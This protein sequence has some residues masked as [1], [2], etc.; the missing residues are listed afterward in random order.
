MARR[1]PVGWG[2]LAPRGEWLCFIDADVRLHPDLLAS[3][4]GDVLGHEVELLRYFTH[5]RDW[6]GR[7]L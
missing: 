7:H 6:K 2:N 5:R 1:M 4:M 3:A